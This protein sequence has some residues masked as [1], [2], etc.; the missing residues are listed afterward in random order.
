M[1]PERRRK[2][3]LGAALCGLQ[4]KQLAAFFGVDKNTIYDDRVLLRKRHGAR[5]PQSLVRAIWTA[6]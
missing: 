4:A 1:S 5:D 6:H 2:V 3:V